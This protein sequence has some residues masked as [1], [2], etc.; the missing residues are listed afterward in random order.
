MSGTTDLTG[1]FANL[2]D[3][4]DQV[5]KAGGRIMD[6]AAEHQVLRLEQAN[7]EGEDPRTKVKAHFGYAALETLK[8]FMSRQQ[9][10]TVLQCMRGE[11][12]DFFFDK[13]IELASTVAAMP[14]TGETD[15]EGAE[16]IVHLHYFAGG[17]AN[18]YITEKDVGS[19]DDE[20]PGQHQAFG[21]ADLFGDGGELGYISI[22]EIIANNGELDFHW[23]PKPLKEINDE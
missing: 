16:A 4:D 9:M 17:Q 22:A 21:K 1:L 15:G 12:R 11:E 7:A 19:A 23:T 6:L 14:K 13:M 20:E 10:A 5:G 18:W 2:P 8:H 3:P